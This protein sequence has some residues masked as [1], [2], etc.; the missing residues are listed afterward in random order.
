M[1][2][3]EAMREFQEH[4]ILKGINPWLLREAMHSVALSHEPDCDCKLCRHLHYMEDSPH[5]ERSPS[6]LSSGAVDD[7][8]QG[9]RK[10]LTVVDDSK[11]LNRKTSGKP[12]GPPV[13]HDKPK[14]RST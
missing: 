1:V 10:G 14:K 11:S 9:L 13:A 2:D 7:E 6:Y 3:Y 4:C 8:P 12:K 5:A